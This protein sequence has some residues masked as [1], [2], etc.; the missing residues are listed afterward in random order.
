MFEPICAIIIGML[1]SCEMTNA[2]AP[3]RAEIAKQKE[4]LKHKLT[5]GV[6]RDAVSEVRK[7]YDALGGTVNVAKGPKLVECLK[8]QISERMGA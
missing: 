8:G 4:R 7:I 5:N 3:N 1:V 6:M 2:V